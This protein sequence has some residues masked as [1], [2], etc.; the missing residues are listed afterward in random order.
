MIPVR[1]FLRA[2][3]LSLLRPRIRRRSHGLGNLGGPLVRFPAK[4]GQ[5]YT[6]RTPA[7][8]L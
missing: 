3:A 7:W 1:H 5:Y 4:R 8:V 6:D 2:G